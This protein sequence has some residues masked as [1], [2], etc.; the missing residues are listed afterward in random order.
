MHGN[1]HCFRSCSVRHALCG[2][3]QFQ[4]HHTQRAGL[5]CTDNAG[6]EIESLT[7]LY[8]VMAVAIEAVGWPHVGKGHCVIRCVR[9]VLLTEESFFI[10]VAMS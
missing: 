10:Q 7:P 2:A 8:A 9:C 5:Y 4:R 6:A 1:V 3:V